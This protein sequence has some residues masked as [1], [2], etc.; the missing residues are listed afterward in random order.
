MSTAANQLPVQAENLPNMAAPIDLARALGTTT[1][2]LRRLVVR[3]ELPAPQ[4]FGRLVRWPRAV[5]TAVL[6]G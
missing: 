1:R 3:G 5:I 2:T 4:R 6:A